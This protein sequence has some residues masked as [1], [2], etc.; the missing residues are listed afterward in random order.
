MGSGG[1][2]NTAAGHETT[3]RLD[4]VVLQKCLSKAVNAGAARRAF[5]RGWEAVRRIREPFRTE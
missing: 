2:Q 5:A 4:V 3:P 1:G